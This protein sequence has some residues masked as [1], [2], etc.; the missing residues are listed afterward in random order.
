MFTATTSRFTAL[1]LAASVSLAMLGGIGAL[2]DGQVASA[3]IAAASA[4]AA[5]A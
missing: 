1:A 5:K 3:Q 4:P 2:A